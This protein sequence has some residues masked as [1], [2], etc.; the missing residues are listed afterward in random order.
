MNVERCRQERGSV[1]GRFYLLYLLR[2]DITEKVVFNL[3]LEE[4]TSIR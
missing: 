1:A 4:G 2:E 3:W